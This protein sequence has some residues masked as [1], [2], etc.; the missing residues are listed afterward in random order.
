MARIDCEALLYKIRLGLADFE[1]RGEPCDTIILGM[2]V[3]DAIL[4]S[5]TFAAATTENPTLYGLKVKRS[6][7]LISE[8][9]QIVNGLSPLAKQLKAGIEAREKC[10]LH[11]HELL[12]DPYKYDL[13]KSALWEIDRMDVKMI[14]RATMEEMVA[15]MKYVTLKMKDDDTH[16]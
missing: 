8:D 3:Y 4:R 11:D 16:E 13:Y 2:D 9:F 15:G 1:E 10:G 6:P 12:Y 14:R 7:Y 5:V